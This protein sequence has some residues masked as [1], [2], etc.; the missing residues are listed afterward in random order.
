MHVQTKFLRL[1]KPVSVGDLIQDWRVCWLGGWDKCHVFFIVMVEK[2]YQ[3][4]ESL[5]FRK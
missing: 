4:P 5:G 2:E 1:C 3:Q